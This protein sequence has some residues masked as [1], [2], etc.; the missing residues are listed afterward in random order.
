MAALTDKPTVALYPDAVLRKNLKIPIHAPVDALQPIVAVVE[1]ELGPGRADRLR[2]ID[3]QI[4]LVAG[5]SNAGEPENVVAQVEAQIRIYV[6]LQVA[7]D[8]RDR[9]K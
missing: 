7:D 9:G 1:D 5:E 3:V 4:D 2:E 8:L 6:I